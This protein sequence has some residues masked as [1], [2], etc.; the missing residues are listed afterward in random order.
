M[1]EK[2]L[3]VFTFQ[4]GYNTSIVM[5]GVVAL[6]IGGG[7]VGVFP[8]LRKRTL[9]SNAISHATLPGIGLAFLIG[10][11]LGGTGRNLMLLMAGA[12]LTG[13][14]GVLAVQWI[15]NH[16][17]LAE[18]TAIGTVLSVFFGFGIVLL[19]HIQTL[20]GGS[21][22]GLNSFLLGSAAALTAA[23]AQLIA[24]SAAGVIT[25]SIIFFKEFAVV[26]FDEDFAAAQG[27]HTT[28]I[29][30]IMM[31]L[32]LAI[33]TIGLKTAGLIL[34]VAL[35]I[36]PP[37]A[38]WFWT[39]RYNRMIVLAGTIGGLSGWIGGTVSALV[40]KVPTG[41][42]IVLVAAA[43]FTLSLLFAPARG[44]IA[45]GIRHILLKFR[46]TETCGLIAIAN[47]FMPPDTLARKIMRWRGYL[48]ING[49]LTQSGA[50]AAEDR[51]R[52][53]HLWFAYQERY[54]DAD[55]TL[56]PLT[57][58]KIESVLPPDILDELKN[59]TT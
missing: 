37:A 2:A 55:R 20:K 16:T 24:F 22:A 5:A 42:V 28:R 4:A 6:G 31:A 41:A 15:K 18:D 46:I 17:R 30:L 29:D 35:V 48:D 13:A 1:F 40:P 52:Q 34:V 19:S 59:K 53:Q 49:K 9:I 58:G 14:L 11:T 33:V 21:P 12:A 27:W 38:A 7:V 51:Q 56:N 26:A 36:I 47:G 43:I 54:P 39:M 32:L 23:E 45:W 8:F 57:N 10:I 50:T 25:I 3:A 44:I